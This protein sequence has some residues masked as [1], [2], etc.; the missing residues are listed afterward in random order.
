MSNFQE[1][2]NNDIINKEKT[3]PNSFANNS[4]EISMGTS[5]VISV[6]MHPTFVL[7]F[8][9]L[10]TGLT[11]L[12]IVPSEFK[13]PDDKVQDIEFVLVNKEG[14][15]I[16]KNTKY[17]SDRNSRAGGI[18]DPK[19]KVS[20]PAPAPAPKGK[21]TPKPK[22]GGSQTV[23]KPV[24]TASAPVT[25]IKKTVQK[26]AQVS[27]PRPLSAPK[28]AYKPAGSPSSNIAR[29][30]MPKLSQAPKSPFSVPVQPNSKLPVGPVPSNYGGTARYGG[31]A[32]GGRGT[33]NGG[34]PSPQFS[35]GSGARGTGTGA[36]ASRGTGTGGGGTGGT[37]RGG[38]GTG[39]YGTNGHGNPG[40]GNP[41]GPPGIDA[42]KQA[43]WGP[44]MR[45]L[46]RRIKRN[47]NPPKGN[48]SKRVVMLFT[49]GR[50]GRL[51]AIK[52]LRSSG[53]PDSDR[54]AKAAIELTAPFKSLPPEFKGNNIDIEFTFDYNVLGAKSYR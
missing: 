24:K 9:A 34:M 1:T 17:R 47:W 27:K 19:R 21:K 49:I 13:K 44:Y 38:T 10:F 8:W 54:A 40:P 48:V 30:Q 14:E 12:G 20:E 22:A 45:E 41:S 52:T 46:E 28:P 16:N 18:H 31:G 42:I 4:D 35:S 36:G 50:D 39:G 6:I 53:Q 32:T 7:I 3:L 37:G 5:L 26:P 11:I 2:K 23:K 15:P 43:D 29:S 33:G 51:I 25:A